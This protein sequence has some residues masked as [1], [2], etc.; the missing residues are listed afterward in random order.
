MESD[1]DEV[2]Y[3][4]SEPM[5]AKGQFREDRDQRPQGPRHDNRDN[6]GPRHDNRDNR[7][8]RQENRDNRGPRQDN[9]NRNQ[10]RGPRPP[11]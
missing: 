11:R 2:D 10:N 1:D 6:R 3:S 9:R 7:G 5:V 4:R 8:P